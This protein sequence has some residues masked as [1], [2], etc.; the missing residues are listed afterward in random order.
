L[1]N[2][3]FNTPEEAEIA[4]YEAIERS[5]IDMLREVWS[6]DDNIVCIHPGADR[7]EGRQ[8]V[9]DSFTELFME[10]PM[11]SF[12]LMDTLQTGDDHL[13]IHL[14][15][16]HVEMG[17]Q[18][19]SSVVSTNIYQFEDGSWRMLLHHA[20]PEPDAMLEEDIDEFE[21]FEALL[22]TPPVLH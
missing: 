22:E 16:E 1:T 20:S 4:F 2:K 21:E 9:L 14:V 17:G 7:I 10:S 8:A 6:T 11:L 18:F 3:T 19:M 5:D 13:A 12:S 15:R